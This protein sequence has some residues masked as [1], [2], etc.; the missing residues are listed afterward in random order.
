LATAG[1]C[2]LGC[3]GSEGG[4]IGSIIAAC[5]EYLAC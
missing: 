1:V 5:E 4:D 2:F 3:G